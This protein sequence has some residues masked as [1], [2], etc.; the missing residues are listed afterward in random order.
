MT[1]SGLELLLRR[2]RVIVV[3]A[4]AV[5]TALAWTY[6]LWLAGNMSAAMPEMPGMN[7]GPAIKPWSVTQF[8][9]SFAVWTVMMI[10]MMTP[11]A[12]P[13][14]L[15]YA[16]V[17]RQ[18]QADGKPFAAA[19]WF[20]AGYLVAWCGF[21]GLASLAQGVLIEAA[22]LTPKLKAASD[23]FGVVVL[24]AAGL[25][26]WTPLKASCLSQCQAPLGFIMRHGGFKPGAWDSLALGLKHGLFCIGCCWAL[27][28]LLFVGGVMNLLWI[29]G[30]AIWVLLEKVVPAGR[31][32]SRGLGL[33]LVAAE[34]IFLYRTLL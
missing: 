9:M 29:A 26:Q 33:V 2:D 25:Y 32:M 28:M 17:A 30:L 4:L 31:V 18:A 13:I 15:L 12:T 22:L 6:V 23:L 21:A 16:R 5:L 19:G 3:L 11:S 34:A 1:G 14:I 20:V 24:I 27:M 7:M 10:G 8:L